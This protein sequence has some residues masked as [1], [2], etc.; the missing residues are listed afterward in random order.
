MEKL[1]QQEQDHMWSGGSY[2]T[3]NSNSGGGG[4]HGGMGGGAPQMRRPMPVDNWA[5]VPGN[6][7]F[8]SGYGRY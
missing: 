8:G 7:G 6:T 4:G 5:G 3:Y 1:E 2:N